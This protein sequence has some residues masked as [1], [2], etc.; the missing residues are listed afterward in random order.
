MTKPTK[1][2]YE[3]PYDDGSGIEFAIRYNGQVTGDNYLG[4]H[5]EIQGA[6][7]TEAQLP[8]EHLDWL[9]NCLTKIREATNDKAD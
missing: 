7:K 2:A 1:I 4:T 5:I 3:I 8:I 9:I 6:S